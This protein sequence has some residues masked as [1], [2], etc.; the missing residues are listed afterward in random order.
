[1]KNT[2]NVG[3]KVMAKQ[4]LH[5][6]YLNPCGG[7]GHCM[8]VDMCST[9]KVNNVINGNIIEVVFGLMTKTVRVMVERQEFNEFFEVIN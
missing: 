6:E 4:E 7:V 5:G 3:H 2:I 9:G 8:S 1:M